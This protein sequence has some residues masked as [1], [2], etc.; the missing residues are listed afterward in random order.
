MKKLALTLGLAGILYGNLNAQNSR[1]DSL[2]NKIDSL[3]AL[4]SAINSNCVYLENPAEKF[5]LDK[6]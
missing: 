6:I 4:M 3:K 5:P 2:N 1:Q